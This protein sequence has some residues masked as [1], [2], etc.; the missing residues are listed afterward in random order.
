[1]ENQGKV[2]SLILS[3]IDTTK[4]YYTEKLDTSENGISKKDTEIV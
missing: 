3:T 2:Q 1:M 4:L